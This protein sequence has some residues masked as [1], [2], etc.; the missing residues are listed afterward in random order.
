MTDRVFGGVYVLVLA[1]D[2][3]G[4]ETNGVNTIHFSE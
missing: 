3:A 2:T 4:L 1:L